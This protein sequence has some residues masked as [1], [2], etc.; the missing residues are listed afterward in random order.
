MHFTIIG[1]DDNRHQ[2]F[3]SQIREILA[4][5]AIYSGGKRHHDIVREWLPANHQWIDITA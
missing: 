4:S 3:P 5:H 2:E 1:I